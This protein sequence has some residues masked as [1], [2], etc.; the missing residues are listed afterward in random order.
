MPA[1]F[2]RVAAVADA[3]LYEGYALYPY[4]GSA[5]K[6]RNGVRWQFGV[7]APRSWIEPRGTAVDG[8]AGSSESWWQQTECLVEAPGSTTLRLRVRHLQ[9]QRRVVG[10][11]S[12]VPFDEAVPVEH[13]LALTLD[14]LRGTGHVATFTVPAGRDEDEARDRSGREDT[15]VL[16]ARERLTLLVRVSLVPVPAPFPVH[17]LRVRV[18]NPDDAADPALAREEALR[19]SLLA[20]HCLLSVDRGRFLSR[21]DPPEWAAEAAEGCRNVRT[22]PVLAGAPGEQDLVLSAPIILYDH[23][24]VAPESPGDLNDASEIDEI[25]SLRTWTL[26]EE[27]KREARATDSR[28]AGLLDRVEAM[29]PEVM[30]R[31]HGAVRALRPVR[32]EAEPGPDGTTNEYGEPT[33]RWWGPGADADVD[34]ERDTVVVDGIRLARGSQVRLR[35]RRR[36]TDAHDMFLAGRTARVERVLR[37][38]NDVDHVAV[39]IE[40]D[41]SAELHQWYGRFHYYGLDE[42]EPL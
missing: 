30:E 7:L 36:G 12:D 32:P 35:P 2:S 15:R 31:L 17:R 14:E 22:F 18:E 19:H 42:V 1:A 25:L 16:R 39:T 23:P 9:L 34:P 24:E 38:V 10:D 6:N 5:G 29:P 11:G 41:P 40:D 4:R 8:V 33:T 27:E 28:V 20:T 21:I 37:D 13:D 26:T 3:V